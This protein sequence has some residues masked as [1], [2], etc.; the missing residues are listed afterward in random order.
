M[1][2][3]LLHFDRPLGHAAHYLGYS[4]TE[5]AVAKRVEAHR[6]GKGST[7]MAALRAAGIGFTLVRLWPNGER[8]DERRLKGHGSPRYCPRCNPR[9]D[10]WGRV[11]KP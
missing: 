5:D 6:V 1:T 3:Y 9:W 8:T 7:L 4:K 2:L 11:P 10:K